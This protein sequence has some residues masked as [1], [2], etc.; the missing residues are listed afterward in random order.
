MRHAEHAEKVQSTDRHREERFRGKETLRVILIVNHAAIVPSRSSLSSDLRA[1]LEVAIEKLLDVVR[2]VHSI[3][4]HSEPDDDNDGEVPNVPEDN[5]EQEDYGRN[6][7]A[8]SVRQ[9]LA[10]ALRA[11]LEHGLYEVGRERECV[12]GLF[13][14]GIRFV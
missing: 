12:Q 10:P 4:E 5:D 7:I 11:L 14:C 9:D 3:A 1:K 6:T 2:S 13:S 8:L